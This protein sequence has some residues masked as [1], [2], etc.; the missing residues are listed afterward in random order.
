MVMENELET[1]I[2]ADEPQDGPVDSVPE[3]EA[4]APEV[5]DEA[6]IAGL[7][8]SL[9]DRDAEISALKQSLEEARNALVERNG[10]LAGAVS[11]YR[12]AI[13]RANPAVLADM[14]A[15]ASVEEVDRSLENARAV[16]EKARREVEA[17]A[18][19]ARVPAGAP[20]R[21]PPDMSALTAREKIQYAL[22]G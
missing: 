16:M 9:A 6:V 5:D 3:S 8:Q 1:N 12:E 10:A 15:G 21:T 7:E 13:V 17:A 14:V 22:G 19:R 11:A 18:L 4:P 2:V 20:Q